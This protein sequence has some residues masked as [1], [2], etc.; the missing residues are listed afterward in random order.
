MA[1]APVTTQQC[2][3]DAFIRLEKR[4]FACRIYYD[5]SKEAILAQHMRRYRAIRE[6]RIARGEAKKRGPK[7]KPRVVTI[8]ESLKAGSC[9]Q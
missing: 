9:A 2:D 3:I 7:P 8:P 5:K 6:E 4:R 1:S